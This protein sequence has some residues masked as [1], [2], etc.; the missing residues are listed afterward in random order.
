ML[1]SNIYIFFECILLIITIF[2]VLRRLI[3]SIASSRRHNNLVICENDAELPYVDVI[4]P[5]KNEA[6]VIKQT[7][8]HIGHVNYPKDKL[9]II[10]YDDASTDASKQ[11]VMDLIPTMAEVELLC[12][13]TTRS[14]GKANIIKQVVTSPSKATVVWIIDADHRADPNCLIQALTLLQPPD[15]AAVGMSNYVTNGFRTL[16][17]T[18]CKCQEESEPSATAKLSQ[19]LAIQ[20][21][22]TLC[23]V[24]AN[25]GENESS[26]LPSAE[27]GYDGPVDLRA[28]RSFAHCQ[29]PASI[30]QRRDWR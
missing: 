17:A 20:T 25:S 15:V 9:R 7:L 11:I 13:P 21:I 23:P 18:Y 10:V 6:T 26:H 12:N 3:Y 14:I 4:I 22:R 2:W 1:L 27:C 8:K 30:G 28:Q 24:F 19:L 29:K 16:I 5:C